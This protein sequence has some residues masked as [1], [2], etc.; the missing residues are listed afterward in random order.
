MPEGRTKRQRVLC[1]DGALVG[2]RALTVFRVVVPVA[3]LFVGSCQQLEKPQPQPF[4]AEAVPPKIQEFRWSNGGTPK[5]FDPALAAAPPETDVVRAIFEGLT[6]IDPRT[7]D[8]K[9]G[10]AES[11]TA[12]D[13]LK[14]WTFKLRTTAKWSNGEPLTAKDVA[15]SWRRLAR[16]GDKGPHRD[17]LSNIDGFASNRIDQSSTSDEAELFLSAEPGKSRSISPVQLLGRQSTPPATP[18]DDSVKQPSDPNAGSSGEQLPLAPP[19]GG[20]S[21]TDDHTFR[22]VLLRGDADLPKL[23]SHPIF[24]PVYGSGDEFSGKLNPKVVTNGAFRISSIDESGISLERSETY[25]NRENVK[26]ER[27]RFVTAESPEKALAA[28]RAGELDAITNIDFSALVL[29]LLTPYED[30]RKTTH[31][32]LNFYEVN[33]A[34]PPFSDRRVRAALSNAIERERLTEGDLGGVTRPALGFLPY[35][36]SAKTKLSQDRSRARELLAEAGYPEGKDF[37]V[38]RLLVNRNDAQQRVA[39][40]V[41]R[42][43]KEALN[44]ETEVIVKDPAEVS[45]MRASGNFDLVRRGVVFPTSDETVNLIAI[46]GPPHSGDS[47]PSSPPTPAANTEAERG[48][49]QGVSVRHVTPSPSETGEKRSL[50]RVDN[51]ILTEEEAV[52]QLRAIPL[53]FPTSFSLIKPYVV[54]FELNSL[55]AIPLANVAINSEWQP[56]GR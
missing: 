53:Y 16:L 24:R 34:K 21:A 46:F 2:S 4:F 1:A 13:D 17:L 55:D 26:L 7:L 20:F 36:S 5:S 44:V 19:D 10:I 33:T 3:A 50:D 11:W 41:A 37:P 25:W 40:S 30:F 47:T 18:G 42:M 54:G 27:A 35:T 32:A 22:V 15:R 23:V 43:W 39:R 49:E 9:P 48:A 6:E 31:S 52:Y 38:I 29:K 14:V 12:S 51:A 28:Y 45:S 56:V 8:A